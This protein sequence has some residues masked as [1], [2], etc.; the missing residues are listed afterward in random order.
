MQMTA[1]L[2]I[3]LLVGLTIAHPGETHDHDSTAALSRRE[4]KAAA[5]RGL[6]SCH[7]SLSKRGGVYDR[8][9]ARRASE[10]AKHLKRVLARDTDAVLNKSHLSTA[11]YS[12]NTPDSVIFASNNSCVLSP[13]GEVGPYWVKG[14][15]LRT[16]L[17]ENEPGV[18]VILEAQF[19]DVETCEPVTEVYWY[20]G[21]YPYLYVES[22][23]SGRD[24]WN[25]N[26]TGVYS[27][28]QASG[29]GNE[30]DARNLNATFLRGIAKADEDGV[31]QFETIFPGHY[32]GRTNHH[33]VIAHLD[34][35]I[36]PNNT[37]VGGTVPYISQL[38]W[39]QDG[40]SELQVTTQ[41]ARGGPAQCTNT[42][43]SG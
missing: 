33:H 29:N 42:Y 41:K 36:L 10:V 43:F 24:L 3:A 30:N 13:D 1:K 23:G 28:V 9:V 7:E 19:L 34:P 31:V 20:A 15:Y 2:V 26:S 16:D 38:F 39:D 32:S 22:N 4:H 37:L 17:R 27:G 25:C 18:P 40:T 21:P 35:T 11:G 6:S 14:E 5:R 8:A 12:P